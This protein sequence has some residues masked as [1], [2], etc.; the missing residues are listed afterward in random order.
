MSIKWGKPQKNK[1]KR[2]DPRHNLND[3]D[4]EDYGSPDYGS[5]QENIEKLKQFNLRKALENPDSLFENFLE[6]AKS[7][8]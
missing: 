8:E 5:N 6:E 2:R 3:P 1:G 7:K 4:E